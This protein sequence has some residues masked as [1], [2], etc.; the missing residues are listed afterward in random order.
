MRGKRYV[1]IYVII[2]LLTFGFYSIS[3][4]ESEKIL[5]IY[6]T[7]DATNSPA[8]SALAE[9][10]MFRKRIED[11]IG[12]KITVSI[13]TLANMPY[14]PDDLN[15]PFDKNGII[16]VSDPI[17]IAEFADQKML[18]ELRGTD[19]ESEV[20]RNYISEQIA[21]RYNGRQ[22]GIILPDLK[23]ESQGVFLFAFRDLIEKAVTGPIEYSP[24][25]FRDLLH[26]L[27]NEGVIPIAVNG[28]PA[29]DG[30]LPVLGLFGL[31]GKGDGEFF[32]DN[33]EVQFSKTTDKARDYLIYTHRLYEDGLIPDDFL[34]INQY[35]ALDIF[36]RRKCAMTVLYTP[37]CI[38][39]MQKMKELFGDNIVLI[40]VPGPAGKS[41]PN[42]YKRIT[43]LYPIGSVEIELKNRFLEVFSR[44]AAELIT[45]VIPAFPSF[46]L[47]KEWEETELEEDPLTL[48]RYNISKLLDKTELDNAVISPYYA[49]IVTGEIPINSFDS[50]RSKWLSSGGEKLLT[51]FSV[52]YRNRLEGFAIY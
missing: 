49:K 28:S 35:S 34:N 12:T 26:N 43:A 18:H 24:D 27:Q 13:N 33:N 37:A 38:L 48:L 4:A 15:N 40:P 44:E 20:F 29:G 30:F 32:F 8:L 36:L 10:E 39:E 46:D 9:N 19:L 47:F 1:F 31:A 6:I 23:N 17:M 42:Y 21:G 11:Q 2:A 3:S 5:H 41:D 14:T 52:Y 45:H 51:M 22:Y 16:F 7:P 25:S 50:M